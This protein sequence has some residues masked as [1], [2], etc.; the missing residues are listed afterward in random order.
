[1]AIDVG[2]TPS[3]RN[4]YLSSG[5]TYVVVSNTANATGI[6][7]VVQLYATTNMS[8]IK[9]AA[10]EGNYLSMTTRGYTSLANAGVGLNTYTAPT[11]FSPFEIRTSD[12]IGIYFTGGTLEAQ[13]PTTFDTF[14]KAGDHIPCTGQE[15]SK[16][17]NI[18]SLYATGVQLPQIHIGAAWKDV[19]NMLINVGDEWKQV[20]DMEINIGDAWKKGVY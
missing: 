5:T 3:D 4:M 9:V 19:Q 13:A 7:T 14:Y 11:D 10:F 18:M 20:C 2:N 15:F 1:M 16:Y 8:G 12:R 6:I 17:A